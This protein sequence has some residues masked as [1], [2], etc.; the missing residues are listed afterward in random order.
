MIKKK[1]LTKEYIRKG[2]SVSDIAIELKCSQSK[3][4]YWIQKHNINKR[5]ISDALYLKNNPNGDPFN[6]QKPCRKEE[7]F[8]YGMGLGLFWGEGNKANKQSVRL[9]NTDPELIGYFIKFLTEIYEIDKSRLR[10]GIQIF[11]DVSKEESLNFWMKK[12]DAPKNKFQGIVVTP[13][14]K[15][16]TYRNR[17]KHG[18]L[19]VYFSNTKLRDIIVGAIDD[20]KIQL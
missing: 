9:G 15:K 12:L 17:N 2:R 4:T 8:L 13:S 10:F 14:R 19:T 16:G 11:S 1:Y 18:V 6:F 3:V 7:W 5:S 20:L